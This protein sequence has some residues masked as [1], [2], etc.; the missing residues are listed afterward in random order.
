MVVLGLAE[1][2]VLVDVGHVVLLALVLRLVLVFLLVVP[3]ALDERLQDHGVGRKHVGREE[4]EPGAQKR[5]FSRRAFRAEKGGNLLV[6]LIVIVGVLG[7][8]HGVLN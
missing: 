5:E 4:G 2:G 3:A 8:L 7:R 6:R 1:E